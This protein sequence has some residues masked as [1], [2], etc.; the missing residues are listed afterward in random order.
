M[1]MLGMVSERLSPD[2][3]L[4]LSAMTRRTGSATRGQYRMSA[5]FPALS[6]RLLLTQ[7]ILKSARKHSPPSAT[8]LTLRFI[9]ALLSWVTTLRLLLT[10]MLAMADIL[11]TRSAKLMPKL[12]QDMDTPL[13]LSAMPRRTDSATRSQCRAHTRFPDK[14]VT[15]LAMLLRTSPMAMAMV[16]VIKKLDYLCY[17]A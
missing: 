15:T 14:S 16:M 13:V 2:T 9:T 7:L 1:D 17:T 10:L 5:R 8:Q 11:G 3:P 6:A 4:V 12:S